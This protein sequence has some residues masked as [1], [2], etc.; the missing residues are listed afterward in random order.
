MKGVSTLVDAFL[1]LPA[2]HAPPSGPY[3][4]TSINY[5]RQLSQPTSAGELATELDLVVVAQVEVAQVEVTQVEVAQVEIAHLEVA[6]KLL[7]QMYGGSTVSD[8]AE[9][10]KD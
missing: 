4:R 10:L 9:T 7:G 2:W 8:Q 6:L 3:G 5:T 1:G